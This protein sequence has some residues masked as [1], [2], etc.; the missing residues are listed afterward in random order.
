LNDARNGRAGLKKS[1]V[2]IA[3][4]PVQNVERPVNA[5]RKE[6]MGR[7]GLRFSRPLQHEQLGKDCNALQPDGEG[8]QD[9]SRKLALTRFMLKF[10]SSIYLYQGILFWKE[11]CQQ[12]TPAQEILY[13]EGV[14]VR[15]M[16]GL[17]IVKHEVDSVGSRADEQNLHA[18]KV[19]VVRFIKRPG[20]I[21]VPSQVHKEV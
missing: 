18:G 4:N 13:F 14:L 16:G 11:Y 7:Y 17:V 8:P 9:L 15:V 20:E 5:E 3:I 12:Y 19:Q 21:Q 2:E 6:I 1:L 10:E